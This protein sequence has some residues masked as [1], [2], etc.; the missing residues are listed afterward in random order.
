MPSGDSQEFASGT[1]EDQAFAS[2]ALDGKARTEVARDDGSDGEPW[3]LSWGWSAG[4]ALAL[5][6]SFVLMR[7]EIREEKD[8]QRAKRNREAY[9]KELRRYNAQLRGPPRQNT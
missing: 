8:T 9:T 1:M 3:F 2:P 4:A 6:A 7:A 5:V